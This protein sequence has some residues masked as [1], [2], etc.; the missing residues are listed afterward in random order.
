[1]TARGNFATLRSIVSLAAS[2]DW[3]LALHPPRLV[4][5]PNRAFADTWVALCRDALTLAEPALTLEPPG[6]DKSD[7]SEVDFVDR[8]S[9]RVFVCAA[10]ETG[11]VADLELDALCDRLARLGDASATLCVNVE[12][13]DDARARLEQSA[14]GELEID[15]A[16]R[17][18][19]RC[20][21]HWPLLAPRFGALLSLTVPQT[22]ALLRETFASIYVDMLAAAFEDPRERFSITVSFNRHVELLTLPVVPALRVCDLEDLLI[23]ALRLPPTQLM[24]DESFRISLSYALKREGRR[25]EESR[26]LGE[27]E[28]VE[29]ALV[30][31]STRIVYE[32]LRRRAIAAHGGPMRA[33]EDPTFQQALDKFE[34]QY[35]AAW[36][37]ALAK[38]RAGAER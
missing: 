9:Q 3:D 29:G 37:S 36:A 20:A 23:R 1:M 26:T 19:A 2:G 31:F 32:A 34:R 35:D 4:R 8:G 18:R 5:D 14:V 7:K 22:L 13:D 24:R 15:D 33:P 6:D 17:W 27:L 30:E 28:L 38:L 10:S 25:L 12:L 21:A 11:R 16:P